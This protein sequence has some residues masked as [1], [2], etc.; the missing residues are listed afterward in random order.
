MKKR[1]PLIILLVL[2]LLAALLLKCTDDSIGPELEKD[3]APFKE[4]C[5]GEDCPGEC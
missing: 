4:A 5:E 3:Q 1:I 2:L